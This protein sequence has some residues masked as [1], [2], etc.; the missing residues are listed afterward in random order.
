MILTHY[1]NNL[2]SLH[3]GTPSG[4]ALFAWKAPVCCMENNVL[5][6]FA[7]YRERIE[8][9]WHAI[10][11]YRNAP[12]FG[13][14]LYVMVLFFNWLPKVKLW[15]YRLPERPC[16]PRVYRSK[17]PLIA[18]LFTGVFRFRALP[19][20]PEILAK[21]IESSSLCSSFF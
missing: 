15:I 19:R 8:C 13:P 5:H 12:F 17:H 3:A 6:P 18:S 20:N 4:A 7:T 14:F 10:L 21:E 1:C 16:R 2:D 11:V 9:S